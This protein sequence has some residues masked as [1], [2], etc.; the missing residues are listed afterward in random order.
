MPRSF[1]LVRS[2]LSVPEGPPR[3]QT[4]VKIQKPHPPPMM[5]TARMIHKRFRIDKGFIFLRLLV[6][7][8]YHS[9]LWRLYEHNRAF[10]AL[11]CRS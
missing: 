3:I 1:S 10:I 11:P 6:V 2:V 4:G 8:V 7:S 9:T 5:I